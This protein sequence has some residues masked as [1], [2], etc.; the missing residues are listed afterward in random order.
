MVLC[1]GSSNLETHTLLEEFMDILNAYLDRYC[2]I[3]G[4]YAN[5]RKMYLSQ[6]WP[7]DDP[8]KISALLQ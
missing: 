5:L 3:R 7:N 2:H 6:L 4:G 8:A 1:N